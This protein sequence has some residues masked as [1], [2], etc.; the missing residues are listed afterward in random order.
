MRLNQNLEPIADAQHGQ[1]LLGFLDYFFG[2][3][4][5]CC[6][7]SAAEVVAIGEASREDDCV[8][9]FEVVVCVPKR[10]RG[11]ACQADRPLGV[12]VV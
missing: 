11:S 7:C 5:L 12:A 3:R 6:Y 1:A 10:N 2:G 9:F 4:G 8:Y